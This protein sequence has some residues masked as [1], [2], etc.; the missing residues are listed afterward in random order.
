MTLKQTLLATFRSGNEA[1]EPGLVRAVKQGLARTAVGRDSGFWDTRGGLCFWVPAPGQIQPLGTVKR[2]TGN[3]YRD[4]K[5]PTP[6][7]PLTPLSR[8]R[9][10]A[11]RRV[12]ASTGVWVPGVVG[13]VQGWVLGVVGYPCLPAPGAP[14]PCRSLCRPRVTLQLVLL[15]VC[16]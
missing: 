2:G 8:V 4:V 11:A 1:F 7:W 16:S 15:E 14:T 6:S 3:S 13:V 12:R 10:G 5:K 9:C